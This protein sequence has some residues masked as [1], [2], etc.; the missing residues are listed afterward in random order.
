M[1]LERALNY[2][3][4]FDLGDRVITFEESTATVKEAAKAL[5]VE[6]GEIAKTLSFI[7]SGNP[8]L[9]LAAGDVKIDNAKFKKEFNEKAH[10]IESSE[11]E[12]LIGHGVGGVCPFGINEGIDVYLD[13]SLKDY[14]TIYPACGTSNSAVKLKLEELEKISNYVRYVDVTKKREI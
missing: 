3:K 5:N 10:M 9:I 14:T 7:V 6:E 12:K 13:E 8:I 4:K 1:A 2:L 11:V